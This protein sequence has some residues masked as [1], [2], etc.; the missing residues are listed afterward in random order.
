MLKYYV[1]QTFIF[2]FKKEGARYS[3]KIYN[4]DERFYCSKAMK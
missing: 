1:S 4:C 2:N 3:E